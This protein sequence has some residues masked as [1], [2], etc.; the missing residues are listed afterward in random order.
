[1]TDLERLVQALINAEAALLAALV[2][3]YPVG[4]SVEYRLRPTIPAQIG[5]V[6]GH[7]GGREARLRVR[8]AKAR[9]D[10]GQRYET[11]IPLRKIIRRAD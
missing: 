5:E 7:Q 1:M 6:I 2:E 3:A 11:S 9:H 10:H 4:C 8:L